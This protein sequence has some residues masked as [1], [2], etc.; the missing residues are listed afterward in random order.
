[1]TSITLDQFVAA[2][3]QAVW[4][5]L[6][7]PDLVQRWWAAGDIAPEVGHEFT[8]DMPG[9][10]AQPCRVL[11]SVQPQRFVY[12]F[13]TEWTLSWTLEPEGRGTRVFL[14]HSGFDLDDKRMAA[15]FERMGP[16]WREVVL[17]RLAET[18]TLVE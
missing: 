13:T 17:P 5:A 4:R 12:T 6:T 8:L 7:E 18:A 1:M 16:G 15:A 9:F 3:P 10:G 11:E 2:T 14:E